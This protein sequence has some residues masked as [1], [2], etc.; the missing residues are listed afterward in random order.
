MQVAYQRLPEPPSTTNTRKM[1]DFRAQSKGVAGDVRKSLPVTC[2]SRC[3]RNE[4]RVQAGARRGLRVQAGPRGQL[5]HPN[6]DLAI[7]LDG[8]CRDAAGPTLKLVQ[9]TVC[10]L[11]G[12]A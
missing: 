12:R 7:V 3:R 10:R 2:A 9:R 11:V 4:R 5:E 6:D 8:E 1:G